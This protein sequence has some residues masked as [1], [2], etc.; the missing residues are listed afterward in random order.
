LN[1]PFESGHSLAPENCREG[2]TGDIAHERPVPQFLSSWIDRY[3]STHRP[4][5]ARIVA[6]IALAVSL[7]LDY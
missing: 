3:L 7:S 5:L 2:P 4:I 1:P 6:L